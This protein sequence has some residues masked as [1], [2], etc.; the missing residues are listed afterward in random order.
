MSNQESLWNL[1]EIYY[2]ISKMIERYFIFLLVLLSAKQ[3]DSIF[4]FSRN[5]LWSILSVNGKKIRYWNFII[6]QI[7]IQWSFNACHLGHFFLGNLEREGYFAIGG[8]SIF[9]F[10]ICIKFQKCVKWIFQVIVMVGV[11]TT[12]SG[13]PQLLDSILRCPVDPSESTRRPDSIASAGAK[14]CGASLAEYFRFARREFIRIAR[15]SSSNCPRDK[16]V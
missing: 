15:H 10:R 7:N 5:R 1:R 2:M 13:A 6:N 14:A 4:D 3:L 9:F 16:W 12:H 8:M 11:W